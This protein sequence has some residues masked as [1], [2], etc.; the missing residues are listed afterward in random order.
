MLLSACAHAPRAVVAVAASPAKPAE[1][2]SDQT[3]SAET[4]IPPES[5][6]L[7]LPN[8]SL[9]G[10]MLYKFLMGDLAVQRGKPDLAAQTYLELAK[11]TRDPRVARRAAQLAYE[12]RQMDKSIEAFGLWQELEPS[13]QLAKQMLISLLVSGGKYQQASPYVEQSLRHPKIQ[14][15]FSCSFIQC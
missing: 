5:P 2:T 7:D 9:D 12:T 11:K 14:V 6:K 4:D 15:V 3:G 1:V 10:D 13:A 8:I